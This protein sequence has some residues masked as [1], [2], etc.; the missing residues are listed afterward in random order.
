M[1]EKVNFQPLIL[2]TIYQLIP[3]E[4]RVI[5]DNLWKAKHACA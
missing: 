3:K 5:Y 2:G 4:H 1:V